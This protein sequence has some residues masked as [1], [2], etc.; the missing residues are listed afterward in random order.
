MNID[1]KRRRWKSGDLDEA[2]RLYWRRWKVGGYQERWSAIRRAVLQDCD[3]RCQL[4]GIP[5]PP[6]Q[7]HHVTY[8]GCEDEDG[9]KPE[10]L[11]HLTALCMECHENQH[12]L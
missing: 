4:C 11:L 3:Y 8:V 2:H 9:N 6:L 12:F 1:R 5:G 7:V 10:S